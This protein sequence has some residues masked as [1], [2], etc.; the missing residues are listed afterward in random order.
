MTLRSLLILGAIGGGSLLIRRV[1]LHQE[2]HSALQTTLANL[3]RPATTASPEHA[4]AAALTSL[5]SVTCAD[6]A[7]VLRQLDDVTAEALVCLPADAL[8]D[9][10]TTPTLFAD[11]IAQDRCLYYPH[12]PATPNPATVLVAQG[13]KSVAVLPRSQVDQVQGAIVLC[14]YHPMQFSPQIQTFLESVLGGMRSLLRFQD[15]TFR[16]DNVQARL[17]AILETIPQGCVC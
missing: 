2:W 4:I 6:G 14:W 16:L 13:V 10:L 12:Y 9:R 11:A 15:I 7:I 17:R 8:P 3:T 5:K 1:L